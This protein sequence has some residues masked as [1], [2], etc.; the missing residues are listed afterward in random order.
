MKGVS[1]D[2]GRDGAWVGDS[3]GTVVAEGPDVVGGGLKVGA[4]AIAP[5]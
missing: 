1:D 4:E 5:A 3:E 2:G